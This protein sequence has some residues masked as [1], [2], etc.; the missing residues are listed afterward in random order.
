MTETFLGTMHEVLETSAHVFGH[1]MVT[2]NKRLK[3]RVREREGQVGQLKGS[4]STVTQRLT[5]AGYGADDIKKLSEMLAVIDAA[6]VQE[7]GEGKVV[8]KALSCD[9]IAKTSVQIKKLKGA[10]AALAELQTGKQSR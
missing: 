1:P 8:T 9:Q 7:L 6:D 4:M 2:E 3:Q 10:K 5:K